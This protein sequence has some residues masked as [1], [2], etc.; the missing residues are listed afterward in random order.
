LQNTS[1]RLLTGH[2][3][4]PEQP[5]NAVTAMAISRQGREGNIHVN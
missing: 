4:N 2:A 3:T 1:R 5:I